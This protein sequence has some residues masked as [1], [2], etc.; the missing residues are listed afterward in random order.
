MG[1]LA[2]GVT[3]LE[4]H[5]FS[6]FQC[7]TF[8]TKTLR[9]YQSLCLDTFPL[10]I[11]LVPSLSSGLALHFASSGSPS[12]TILYKIAHKAPLLLHHSSE[13]LLHPD[14]LYVY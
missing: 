8:Y 9:V 1:N 11:Q 12:H 7:S 4:L 14:M 13:I 5:K 6:V 10:D 2:L 3:R